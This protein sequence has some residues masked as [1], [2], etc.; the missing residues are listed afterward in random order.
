[1]PPT[2]W[3]SPSSSTSGRDPHRPFDGRRR[4][5]RYVA[6]AKPG[7]VAKA[8][9]ISAVPPTWCRRTANPDGVPMT[10]FDEI[11]DGSRRQPRAILSRFHD[12]LLRLQPR[13]RRGQEGVRRNWWRQGMMGGAIAHVDWAS[14]PSPRPISPTTS[15]RSRCRRSCCTARTT[16]SSRSRFRRSFGQAAPRR[17]IQ[18]L[19]GLSARHADDARR[20]DQRRPARLRRGVSLSA[21][22]ETIPRGLLAAVLLRLSR[23]SKRRDLGSGPG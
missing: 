8:V 12:A 13:R 21:A 5:A 22:R 3:R 11:R 2:S 18:D 6:H 19:S 16:R 7:R 14:R 10:V 23:R 4:G 17:A 20:P 9:L 15:R 1:M